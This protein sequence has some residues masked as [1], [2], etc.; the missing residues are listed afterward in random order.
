MRLPTR[1]G[2]DPSDRQRLR[3]QPLDGMRAN[4]LGRAPVFLAAC[5]RVVVAAAIL[6]I[7]TGSV[8]PGGERHHARCGERAVG[9]DEC[10]LG[11]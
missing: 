7:R 5:T 1:P 8:S 9:L 4:R 2:V 3:G 6:R 11:V 10:D